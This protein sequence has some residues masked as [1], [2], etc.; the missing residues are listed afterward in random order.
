M[1]MRIQDHGQ[2][3]LCCDPPLFCCHPDLI[4]TASQSINHIREL[5]SEYVLGKKWEEAGNL[6]TLNLNSPCKNEKY[7]NDISCMLLQ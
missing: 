2:S 7:S 3:Q 6:R 5:T 4:Q 1:L